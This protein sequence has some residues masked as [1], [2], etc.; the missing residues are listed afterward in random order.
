MTDNGSNL[1]SVKMDGQT[2]YINSEGTTDAT[3]EKDNGDGTK[4]MSA[5]VILSSGDGSKLP[6]GT[7]AKLYVAVK[8]GDE[9]VGWSMKGSPRNDDITIP[10]EEGSPEKSLTVTPP[11]GKDFT[12][13][14]TEHTGVEA[15]TGYT[16]SGTA[17]AIDAGSYKAT[18]TLASGYKWTDGSSTP[19]EILWTI[20][21]A[22][23]TMTVKAKKVTCKFKNKKKKETYKADQVYDIQNAK[24]DVRFQKVEIK[25]GHKKLSKKDYKKIAVSQTTGK[26]TIKKGLP[27]GKY[28]VKVT[29]TASGN[30]NYT[31]KSQDVTV[32]ITVK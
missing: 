23:N 29:L 6:A 21:Q 9:E 14:G 32:K 30:N 20:N 10:A 16:L 31:S 19:K 3:V 27:K 24:G 26:I 13:D 4:D 22:E 7:E 12:Y 1:G 5:E 2:Y 17:K 15:G 25:R 28:K 18:A 11:T 8:H